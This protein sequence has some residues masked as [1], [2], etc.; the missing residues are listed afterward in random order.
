MAIITIFQDSKGPGH[1]RSC[2]ASITWAETLAH[3]RMPFDGRIIVRQQD[4]ERKDKATGRV[5]EEV[6]TDISPTHWG[7]CPDAAKFKRKKK[8]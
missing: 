1:C 3:K 4:V 6:D 7:T 8:A 5:L 2:K